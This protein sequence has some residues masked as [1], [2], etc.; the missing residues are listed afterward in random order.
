METIFALSSGSVPAGVAVVRVSGPGAAGVVKLYCGA[1]PEPRRAVLRT[2]RDADGSAIDQALVLWLPGPA[3]FTGEDTA[4]LHVHGSRAVLERLFGSLAEQP[5]FR[6]AGPGE[7]SRRAFHNGRLDLAELEGTADLIAAETEVQRRQALAVASG[8]L[9]RRAED[10]RQRL[11]TLRAEIEA[12][13]DFSDEGDVEAEFPE[14]FWQKVRDFEAELGA[15]LTDSKR[16]ERVRHGFRVA[17][18][19]RPNA[20]KSTLLNALARRDVAI[21]TP[22]PGTTRDVVEV[23]LDLRGYPVVIADTAGIRQAGSLAEQEGVRRAWA[24]AKQADLVLWLSEPR[25]WDDACE[26]VEARGYFEDKL[27]TVAS[28]SDLDPPGS[29]A[30]KIVISALTGAGL[31]E[32]LERLAEAAEQ[33]M[34]PDGALIARERHRRALADAASLLAQV[35]ETQPLEIAAD[36]LRSAG[37]A[38]GRI[39]GRVDIEDVL[40]SLFREFCVGK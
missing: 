34:G 13:L 39:S 37:D 20:G 40:D 27:W 4:E 16:G 22:E 11:I 33:G 31:T 12:H 36:L 25:T 28:K 18:L 9:S 30:G 23:S 6:P 3:T 29:P 7:F 2:L 38:I 19:G 1:L 17:L 8:L 32:L 15:A 10:W 5:K 24:A 14:D 35:H 26:A 21:V